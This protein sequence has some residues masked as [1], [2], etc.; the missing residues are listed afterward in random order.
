MALTNSQYESIM[1]SYDRRQAFHRE[2]QREHQAYAYERLPGLQKLDQEISSLAVRQA[3]RLLEGD[4]GAVEELK[5]DTER[6]SAERSR[7]LR[8]GG[9]PAD[10]LELQYEC[11]NCKDTGYAGGKKCRCFLQKELEVLYHQSRIRERLKMEN[12]DSCTD[13]CYSDTEIVEGSAQT[14]RQYMRHVIDDCHEYVKN[15]DS[16]GENLVLYGSAGVGKTFLAGCIAKELIET[17]HSVVYLSAADLFD[18]MAKDRFHKDEED[19]ESGSTQSILD[20]DLL[21]IDDLGTEMI[22]SWTNSQLFYCLNKRLLAKKATIITTNLTPNQLS[23]E[24]SDR[25]GSRLIESFRFISFPP[26]DVRIWKRIQRA[27]EQ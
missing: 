27:R 18:S 22:N 19:D 7:L 3:R 17:Y 2:E 6:I 4:A 9:F 10:Y 24:Y 11:P 23:R 1:R 8:E 15:F 13:L 21:I 25:V 16:K 5:K 26:G 12:F 20:C 14:A